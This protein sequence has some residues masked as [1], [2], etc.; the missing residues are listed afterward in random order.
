MASI[1]ASVCVVTAR[2]AAPRRATSRTQASTLQRTRRRSVD[3]V[4]G[5]RRGDRGGLVRC[6]AGERVDEDEKLKRF[7]RGKGVPIPPSKKAASTPTPKKPDVDDDSIASLRFF[8]LDTVRQRWDV[9]WGGWRVFFGLS[10]WTA[11]FVLTAGVVA[12][13]LLALNGLDPR[14]FTPTEKTQYLLAIQ[15]AETGIT[16]AVLYALLRNYK[17]DM[18]AAGDWFNVDPTSDAFGVERGWLRWALYGYVAVFVSIGAVAA[19]FNLGGFALEYFNAHS[20]SSTMSSTSSLTSMD[21]NALSGGG[22]GDSGGGVMDPGGMDAANIGSNNMGDSVSAQDRVLAR[23]AARRESDGPGTI[24]AVLPLIGGGED[25]GARLLSLLAVT[26]VFAP[27]LE[28]VVFRG[29]LMTSL[30]KWLPTPGA[31]L[32]SSVIFAGAHF[33][34]RDFPQLVC[35]GMVLGFSYAR[36]RNLLTPMTIHAM[37]NSGVLV[38]IAGLMATGQDIPGL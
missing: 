3:H 33:S 7:L 1:V 27:A 20:M 29:F 23:N 34:A 10:G 11:S 21:V 15:A 38:V 8:D 18:D 5:C 2:A 4:G 30:T 12:P 14:A 35:L 19:V 22:G 9:P 28:E 25:Q 37:W 24:D 36:T 31:V 26:S 17:N 6:R 13:V 32:F 16:F